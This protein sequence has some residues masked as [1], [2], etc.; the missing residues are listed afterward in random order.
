MPPPERPPEREQKHIG[1]G[2][3]VGEQGRIIIA[4]R[5][6]IAGQHPGW[7][8]E[9]LVVVVPVPIHTDQAQQ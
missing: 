2:H 3:Q 5:V 8:T 1:D 9:I 4:A 7:A 6:K